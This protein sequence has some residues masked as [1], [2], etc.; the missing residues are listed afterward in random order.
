MSIDSTEYKTTLLD[1]L[2]DPFEECLTRAVAEKLVRLRA[3]LEIIAK[4]EK[5]TE[6]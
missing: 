2:L 6:K 5:L 4:V 3:N 1:S